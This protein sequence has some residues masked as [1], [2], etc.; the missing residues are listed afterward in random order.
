MAG[1]FGSELAAGFIGLT[2]VM[3]GCGYDKPNSAN[4][5]NSG[6][7]SGYIAAANVEARVTTASGD[8]TQALTTFRAQLGDPANTAVGEN[9]AGGRREINW[10]AVP[11][12]LSNLSNFPGDQ[13]NRVVPRGQVFTTEGTG[14][15]VSTNNLFDLNPAYANEFKAFS[16]NNI[17][18]AVGSRIIRV[19]FQVAGST[20][21]AL[22]NGFGVVFSDVD[23]A[24]STSLAFF[25]AQGRLLKKVNAP[26][27][28][29]ANGHSFVG[30]T[31]SK[32]VVARVR[33]TAGAA[34][35]TGSNQ[36]ISAGGD[37]DLVATDDFIA[38]EPHPI[39]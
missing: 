4:D 7:G 33:I 10:D 39:R 25:D 9:Q 29:D 23:V 21:P 3:A 17:F 1:R 36:D 14:F 6:N 37:A 34:G 31:F 5:A 19:D 20:T 28:S 2:L 26:V 15:R 8:L 24:G 35:I 38:G 22:T 11:A 18:I 12:T 27:R 13:F 16:P 30:V 32:T